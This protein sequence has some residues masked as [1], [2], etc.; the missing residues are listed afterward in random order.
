[1]ATPTTADGARARMR[2]GGVAAKPLY[3]RV[4]TMHADITLMNLAGVTW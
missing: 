1:M 3:A 2:I 4:R